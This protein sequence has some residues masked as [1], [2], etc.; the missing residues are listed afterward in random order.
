MKR[1]I[2]GVLAAMLSCSAF[3]QVKDYTHYYEGLPVEVK[4]V[5]AVT[6]P[7]RSTDIVRHGAVGDGVTLCTRAIQAAIDSLAGL[8]GGRVE[9]PMGI[10]LP[11]PI[12]LR[13]NINLVLD[14]NAIL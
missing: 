8:G 12:E 10:W 6:F 2:T 7:D 9:I 11:G 4:Q 13:S 3:A 5:S 1:I 14:K